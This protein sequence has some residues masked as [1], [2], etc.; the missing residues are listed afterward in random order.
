MVHRGYQTAAGFVLKDSQNTVLAVEPN[1]PA[2]Q[3]GLQ[4]GDVILK[5][6]DNDA[7]SYDKLAYF[8]CNQWTAGKND[9][10]LSVR[11]ASGRLETLPPFVPRTIG[12]HPTQIYEAISM[13]LLVFLLL[14]YYPFKKRDGSVMVLFMI[15]YAVHRFLNEMLRTDT[16]KIPP[17]YLTL[18]QHISLLVLLA[19]LM[20]G[21]VIYLRK[22]PAPVPLTGNPTTSS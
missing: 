7:S 21:L 13:A 3:A 8:L 22:L 10:Q 14:A 18:S 9:L 1:S 17:L 19:G 15:C 12:L 11:H 2:E 4:K 20:L 6:N 16:E 5:I